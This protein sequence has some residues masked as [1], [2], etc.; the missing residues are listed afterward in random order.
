MGQKSA[1]KLE[2]RMLGKK[3]QSDDESSDDKEPEIKVAKNQGR[4]LKGRPN[5]FESASEEDESGSET[6]SYDSEYE[7]AER[8]RHLK[9]QQDLDRSLNIAFQ[10]KVLKSQK[11]ELDKFE[12]HRKNVAGAAPFRYTQEQTPD[13]EL[14]IQHKRFDQK[15]RNQSF[16]SLN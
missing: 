2:R 10:N 14:N 9:K 7:E 1:R 6:E 8:N 3:F 15:R 16:R 11:K 4:V 5:D 13:G 12:M